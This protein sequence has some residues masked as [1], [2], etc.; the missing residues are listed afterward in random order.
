LYNASA[1]SLNSST[2]LG[3][4]SCVPST[5]TLREEEDVRE[6][7]AARGTKQTADGRATAAKKIEKNVFMMLSV[8]CFGMA[9][10]FG[11]QMEVVTMNILWTNRQQH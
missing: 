8:L 5:D 9:I 10:R 4:V 3:G 7:P 2:F 11:N 1:V 6:R